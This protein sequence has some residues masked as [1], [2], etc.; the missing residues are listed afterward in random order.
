MYSAN[1]AI[2]LGLHFWTNINVLKSSNLITLLSHGAHKSYGRWPR[3][4]G[5]S[6]SQL[7]KWKIIRPLFFWNKIYF[8]VRYGN[9]ESRNKPYIHRTFVN[10]R[11]NKHGNKNNFFF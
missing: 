10:I 8:D 5:A 11:K 2:F 9:V 7:Y 3:E 6:S 1:I 4:S